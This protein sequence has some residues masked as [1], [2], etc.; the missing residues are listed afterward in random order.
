M[1]PAQFI[2]STWVGYKNAIASITGH[3]P[4]NPWNNTD[5]FVA[6]ALYLKSAGAAT[7]ERTAAAKYYCGGNWNRYVC[8][9]VYGK[10]VTTRAASFQEDIDVLNG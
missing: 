7:N 1:G 4:P 9:E 8:T 3:N 2:P 10:G 6:T 5:A